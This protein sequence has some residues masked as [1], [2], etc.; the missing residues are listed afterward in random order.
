MRPELIQAAELLQR[1]TPEAVEEA[2]GLLQNTI[3]SFSMKVCGHPEDAED[4]MQEVLYRSLRHLAKIQNPQALAVWLYTVTR[5]RCWRMRRKSA[6]TP[7]KTLSLDELMPDDA[8]LGQL[9][10][11]AAEGPEGNLLQAEQDH[12][13]HQAILRIPATLRIVL[14]LHDMEELTTEQVAQILDLKQGTVRIR[15]HRA[16]LAVRKEMN[17]TLSVAAKPARQSSAIAKRQVRSKNGKRPAECS[18][19]F[20]NLSEYLDDRVEPMTCEQ[21]RVHI[22]ACPSCVAFLRN[23]RSAIDRCRSLEMTCDPAVAG[24]LRA[25]LTRE[26]LRMLVMPD[27]KKTYA[28]V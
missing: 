26:Y 1:D 25:I 2:L 7:T 13:L 23:L 27:K 17:H 18:E 11:D 20:A 28:A 8:E 5:N 19:L 16:R 15:L 21:M 22:E 24:R 6:G 12:Q 4:N 3:Y 9:L 10:K 14:V